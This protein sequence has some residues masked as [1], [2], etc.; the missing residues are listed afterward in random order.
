MKKRLF[1]ILEILLFL[2]IISIFAFL[3]PRQAVIDTV[4]SD[5][6]TIKLWYNDDSL[7]DYLLD[8]CVSFNKEQQDIRVV[9]TLITDNA[10][11]DRIYHSSVDGNDYPDLYII[12]NNELERAW[13]TGLASEVDDSDHIHSYITYPRTAL[14]SVTYKNMVI[15]YPLSFSVSALLYN[16]DSLEQIAEER[17][18][19]VEDIIP[20]TFTDIVQ[21]ANTYSAPEKVQSILQWDASDVFYNYAFVGS[22]LNIGGERGDSDSE[23]EVYNKQVVAGM[24]VYQQLS[25]FFS[26]DAS[27]N[28]DIIRDFADGKIVFTIAG[29]DAV[30]KIQQILIENKSELRYGVA[31][32]PDITNV[33][34][35]RPLSVTTCLAVNGYSKHKEAANVF[36]RYLLYEQTDT[37]YQLCGKSPAQN[38]Y[39]CPDDHMQGFFDA[40]IVSKPIS[41]L[42]SMSNFWI[43]LENSFVNVWNGADANA[44]LCSLAQTV[45]RQTTGSESYTVTKLT[46]LLHVDISADLTGLD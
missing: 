25:Q 2:I 28:D 22:G 26:F 19:S 30:A 15:A 23:I 17:Q 36:A 16:L 14:D 1:R 41:K 32:I 13:M 7:S 46:D 4:F 38:N 10:Y 18:L 24:Q 39:I 37:L 6:V 27:S 5:K 29:T 31:K 8:A 3:A 45:M 34:P 20:K 35:S 44:E 40:Y 9:P 12:R 21:L 43:L 11:F 33:L 42:R